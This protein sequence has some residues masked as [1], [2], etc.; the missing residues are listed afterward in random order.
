VSTKQLIIRHLEARGIRYAIADYWVAYYTSFV[1]HE[2]II[3]TP[4]EFPRIVEYD[5][6]VDAHRSEAIRIARSPCA[7][8]KE[9]I[10]GI[11]FCPP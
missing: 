8:G 7:G 10:Q 3:V 9:V 6:Q 5:R 1:T 4:E 2:R 11:Y